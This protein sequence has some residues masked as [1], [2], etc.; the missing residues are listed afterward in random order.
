MMSKH[1][2]AA[3][4]FVVVV[5][6]ACVLPPTREEMTWYL[7]DSEG[8]AASYAEYMT[9]WPKGRH[10]AEARSDFV[11]RTM[12]EAKLAMIAD[13]N[14]KKNTEKADPDAGRKRK[15]KLERFFWQEVTKE[16]TVESYHNYLQRYPTGLFAAQ[17][18]R[19][20]DDLPRQ[21]TTNSTTQ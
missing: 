9:E 18:H 2:T 1:R 16:N 5:G 20:M 21:S 10:Y 14:K 8:Q 6:L 17:A 3:A 13:A 11:N 12:V 7:A 4:G 15:E 19:Q